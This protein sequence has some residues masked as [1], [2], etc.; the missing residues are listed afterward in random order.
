M[1]PRP[2][3]LETARSYSFFSHKVD[4]F[5]IFNSLW[6]YYSL[7]SDFACPTHSC[8]TPST[9]HLQYENPKLLLLFFQNFL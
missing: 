9:N 6:E 8:P 1:L 5:Y 2:V 3:G 7:L 4:F